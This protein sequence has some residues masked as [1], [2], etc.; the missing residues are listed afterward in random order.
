MARAAVG[1]GL[2]SCRHPLCV[3]I[4]TATGWRRGVSGVTVL[5]TARRAR[6]A[7]AEGEGGGGPGRRRNPV[8]AEG[9]A[10]NPARHGLPS[11]KMALI[12]SDCGV[13]SCLSNTALSAC[14][15]VPHRH[16]HRRCLGDYMDSG[17]D[18]LITRGFCAVQAPPPAAGSNPFGGGSRHQQPGSTSQQGGPGADGVDFKYFE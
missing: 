14:C 8:G 11:K 4:E 6:R 1:Q 15:G 10:G 5:P 17:P 7:L 2:P 3:P 9:G 18:H 12:T 16:H 13:M